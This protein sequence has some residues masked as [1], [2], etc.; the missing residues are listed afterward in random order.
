MNTPMT[1]SG[2]WVAEGMNRVDRVASE[3]VRVGRWAID[4]TRLVREQTRLNT[5]ENGVFELK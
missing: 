5:S 3:E 1:P 4:Q 2:H